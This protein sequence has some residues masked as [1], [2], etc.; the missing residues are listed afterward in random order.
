MNDDIKTM[1]TKMYPKRDPWVHKGDL[2][3]VMV[4]SGSH[5]Y[6]GSPVFNAMGA[7][8]A[9]ADLVVL[10][11]HPRAMDIAAS[12]AP[13]II[14]SPFS[15]EFRADHVKDVLKELSR[16]QSLVIGS[17]MERSEES[18]VAIRTLVEK[19]DIPMVLDAEALRAITGHTEIIKGKK[20]ILTPNS[21]EFRVLTGEKVGADE[22]ER[23]EKV[24]RWAKMFSVTILLK[25]SID[26]ISDGENI[27]VNKTGS[28]YMTKGGFGDVLSGI[29]GAL[30]ARGGDT[31]SVA[32][33]AAHING[34][35]G[36][37]A[38]QKYGEGA[39]ASDSLEFI[40]IVIKE[41]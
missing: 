27:F 33:V 31:F 29:T 36:D 30:L 12:Y 24:Q 9:G 1:A 19:S 6:S 35:A 28:V 18:F 40:P 17:G 8:R 32:C 25:G 11:G 5:T 13:D 15:G 39:L 26:I 3:Y 16:Y 4:V 22:N 10:R 38:G 23:K 14:T 2:G 37:L 21:E 41:L 34:E 20:I 7:L